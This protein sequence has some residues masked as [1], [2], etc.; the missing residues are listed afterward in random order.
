MPANCII[1]ENTIHSINYFGKIYTIFLL[2]WKIIL[3]LTKNVF[4]MEQNIP[5]HLQPV[6]FSSSD[7][8][9]SRQISKLEK[10]GKIRKIAPRIYTPNFQESPADIIKKNI[11]TIIGTLYPGSLLSHRSALEYKPTKSGHIFVTHSYTK[12]INLPGITIRFLQGHGPIRGDRKFMGELYVS[13]RERALLEN[14]QVS[15]RTG[16]ES[17][18][19]TL[20]DIEARLEKIILINGETEINKVRDRARLIANQLEMQN[21]FEKLNKLIGALLTTKSSKILTSPLAQARAFGIPYDEARVTLFEKL[22]IEL[23]KRE[24]KHRPDRNESMKSFRNFAFFESYFSNYIE[25]T[26]FDVDEAKQI[27]ETQKPLPARD[28]D[29]H[30]VLGTYKMVSSSEEMSTTPTNSEEF[31]HILLYR[32]AILLSGRL[33]KNPGQF[34]DKNNYAGNTAFVDITLTRGTL[35]KGFDFY[36]A[37]THPFAKAA[38]IMFIVSE[39]HPFLDGNGR[40]ARIMMNAE[41]TK[42]GQS[43][44]MI[45]TVYREDYIGALRKL[46]MQGE[47]DAY[48]RMLEKIHAFSELVYDDNMDSMQDYLQK[49]NA[50]LEPEKGKLIITPG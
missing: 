16:A 14:L 26:V 28:E 3:I 50:F 2:C 25:G 8:L 4:I 32:H 20:P 15:K 41:L 21:E 33:Y 23:Q 39:V 10:E 11:L 29:S 48:I 18:T 49:S 9:L 37:I 43:K 17:K 47:P 13:G 1:L 34:K 44:I 22:F 12:K 27:I 42:Q 40:L 24:F 36:N 45:P 31:L 19:L 38:Y 7:Q 30:D 46:T 6:I 35:I 5:L